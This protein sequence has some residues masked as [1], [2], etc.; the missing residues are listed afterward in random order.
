MPDDPFL[1]R[2]KLFREHVQTILNLATGSLVVSVTFLTDLEP[3]PIG[4][5]TLR[6][7]WTSLTIAILLSLAY[8]YVLTIFVNTDGKKFGNLLSSLSITLHLSFFVGLLLLLSFGL[9][10]LK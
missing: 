9:V 6:W 1:E 8:N 10:N 4:Q 2:A 3:T 7:S 5:D